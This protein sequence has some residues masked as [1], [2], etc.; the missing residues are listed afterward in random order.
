MPEQP[1]IIAGNVTVVRERIERA[2]TRAG[3]SPEDITLVS[4]SKTTPAEKIQEAYAAGVRHFGESRTQEWEAKAPLLAGLDATWHLVG[5]LQRNKAT[6]ALTLF[7]EI[8]SVDNLPLAERLERG[9]GDGRH[10]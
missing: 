4:V 2:A 3:R 10:H 8:D 1:G 9:A 5:H 6:R 7:H